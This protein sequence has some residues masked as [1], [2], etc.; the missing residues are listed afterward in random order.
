MEGAMT[1]DD[2]KTDP[3]TFE[4][5]TDDELDALLQK[6]IEEDM[7]LTEWPPVDRY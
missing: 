1:T 3:E 7:E 6:L 2:E 5:M 4:D